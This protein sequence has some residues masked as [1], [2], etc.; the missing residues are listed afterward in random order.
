MSAFHAFCPEW[1]YTDFQQ[2]GRENLVPQYDKS[3]NFRRET[4]LKCSW[5]TI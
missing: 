2:H 1:P 4:M 3:P 5:M